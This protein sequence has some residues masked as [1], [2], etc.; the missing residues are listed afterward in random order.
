[1]TQHSNQKSKAP[2]GKPSGNQRGGDGLKDISQNEETNE[3][4]ENKYLD[5]NG[6]PDDS[7]NLRHE[8][9][10]TDKGQ[11]DQGKNTASV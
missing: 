2:K 6:Q 1:M 9:R 4:L 5:T 11:E 10:N 3:T 8:N 7:V